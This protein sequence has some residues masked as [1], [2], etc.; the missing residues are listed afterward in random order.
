[1]YL[2]GN[3]D[4]CG[5]YD[6]FFTYLAERSI[7]VRSYDPRG[8]GRS[9]LE[10][11][12]QGDGGLPSQTLAEKASFIR[13]QLSSSNDVPLFVMGYSNGA[14]CAMMLM[15]L[16]DYADLS[17]QVRGWLL[18]S[19]HVAMVPR[20][21]RL[22]LASTRYLTMVIPKM[23]TQNG[24][25]LDMVTSNPE[26]VKK[27]EADNLFINAGTIEYFA[28]MEARARALRT[29]KVRLDEAIQSVWVAHGTGDRWT[30]YDASK[31]WFEKQGVREDGQFKTYD[32]WNHQLHDDAP[33]TSEAFY[34]DVWH[35][36][37]ARVS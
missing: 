16:P 30:S 17:T 2:L 29:G 10:P 27:L 7:E 1:V 31:A 12:E 14:S 8:F 32:G 9:A 5:L 13:T 36:I 3:A 11:R 22:A 34:R 26:V 28:G 24:I 33:G 4:H 19:P 18:S 37:Q 25:K 15:S 20:T 35:W 23:K 6:G 21:D